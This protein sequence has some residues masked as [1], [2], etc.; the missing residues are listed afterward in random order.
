M[1]RRFKISPRRHPLNSP[2]RLSFRFLAPLPTDKHGRPGLQRV[3]IAN[4]GEIA[5]RVINTCRLLNIV[6]SPFTLTTDELIRLGSIDQAGGNLYLNAELV[7]KVALDA[8]ADGIHP[9]YGY[10]SENADFATAVLAAR[11]KFIG[12]SASTMSTLGD[13]R[14]AKAFLRE[15]DPTVPLIPGFA[16]SSSNANVDMDKVAKQI[17]YP[18]M[19]KASAGGGGKRMR[20]VSNPEQLQSGL[21]RAQPE[22]QRFFGSSDCIL[23]KYIEAYKHIEIQIIGDSHGNVASLGE[24][25]CSVQRRHQKVIEETPSPWLTAEKRQEM[26]DVAVRI[27]QLLHYENAGTVEFV[28]DVA[29]SNFYFLEVNTRLQ[30]EHPITEEVTRL[31]IVSLQLYVA[32]GGNLLQ[33][34]PLQNIPQIDYA[35]ECRLYAEDPGREFYPS[36]G[37]IR[38]WQPATFTPFANRTVRFETG[39]DTGSRISIYFDSMIAKIIVWEPNTALA[40]ATM[41]RVL[42]ETACVGVA[43]NHLFSQRPF[44]QCKTP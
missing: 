16:G 4:R 7:V 1:L 24:R 23:E 43:T 5:C 6:S 22:A 19:L 20:I 10:L 44:S 14:S 34:E 42:A 26:S 15:N 11:I 32:A 37:L 36:H 13:K 31:D 17:G 25:D 12:P 41:R 21:E 9:G 3:L 39:I 28:F 27:G 8:G 30:V 40:R 38:L 29:T 35:I 18:I 33:L 2:W